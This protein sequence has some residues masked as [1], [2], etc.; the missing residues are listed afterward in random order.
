MKY[1]GLIL[2]IITCFG[3]GYYFSLRLKLRFVFLSAF[4]DF[5][6]ALETN[7]RYNSSDIFTL[8]KSSA[9]EAVKDIFDKENSNFISYWSECINSIPKKYALKNDDYNIIY[10]FGKMLGTSD[11][12]GEIKHIKLYEE[13]I[14]NNLYNSESELKQKSKLYKLLGL[15]AGLTIA[16]LML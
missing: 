9:P 2:I 1:V 15:F 7:L 10:E 6:S 5:L 12:E 3:T 4:K 16:L 14:K 11:V 13:L 8:V